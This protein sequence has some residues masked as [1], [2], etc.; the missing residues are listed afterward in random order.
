M[1]G[2]QEIPIPKQPNIIDKCIISIASK[3]ALPRRSIVERT[4]REMTKSDEEGGLGICKEGRQ[5]G[6]GR[7]RDCA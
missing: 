1:G 3:N 2:L 6:E 4:E 5:L 7:C